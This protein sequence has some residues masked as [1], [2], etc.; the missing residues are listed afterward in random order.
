MEG[1][2][3]CKPE[4]EPERKFNIYECRE[5]NSWKFKYDPSFASL[6]A[7]VQ[8]KLSEIRLSENYFHYIRNSTSIYCLVRLHAFVCVIKVSVPVSEVVGVEEGRVEILPK[9]S[10]EDTDKDFTGGVSFRGANS[11]KSQG[12]IQ[13]L[14]S[15]K[16][17]LSFTIFWNETSLWATEARPKHDIGDVVIL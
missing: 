5:R 16:G 3:Y 9:K 15:L 8:I 4:I 10:V 12:Y 6:Q 11:S 7:F 17:F 1:L 2:G 13:C 14:C